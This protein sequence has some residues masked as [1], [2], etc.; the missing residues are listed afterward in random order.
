[1]L[2]VVAK[3]G[4]RDTRATNRRLVL[5]SLSEVLDEGPARLF[6]LAAEQSRSARALRQEIESIATD[7]G[8]AIAPLIVL[9]DIERIT[10]RRRGHEPR[11]GAARCGYFH[12]T[13]AGAAVPGSTRRYPIQRTRHPR[14][15]D[16]R[17]RSGLPLVV[18]NAMR[19]QHLVS[20]RARERGS[21]SGP[22]ATIPTWGR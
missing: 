22:S 11:A 6:A 10:N 9:L 3:A 4:H 20:T 1:M 16:W 2:R 15:V 19:D 14:R 18:R 17:G 8:T 13:P 7:L 21:K 5:Q 12:C